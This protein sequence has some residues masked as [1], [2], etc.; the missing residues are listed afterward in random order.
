MTPVEIL[1][2]IVAG[3]ALALHFLPKQANP[4]IAKAQTDVDDV[5]T[6][7]ADHLKG[8]VAPITSA[9]AA[10]PIA[11]V[12]PG[13]PLVGPGGYVGT[14]NAHGT[15]TWA[16]PVPAGDT[17]AADGSLLVPVLAQEAVD[18]TLKAS[19]GTGGYHNGL[20]LN[21]INYL[22]ALDPKMFAA[23]CASLAAL[24]GCAGTGA[25]VG[26]ITNLSSQGQGIVLA[27]AET[28]L[29]I[30]DVDPRA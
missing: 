29:V 17:L 20:S 13:A 19:A 14:P 11:P 28:G 3:L 24:P 27:L 26:W 23:W 21:Q 2:L 8:H 25:S 6:W 12:V 15:V 7:I 22:K 10:Q 4:L 5:W 30:P 16:L 1:I 18:A 9:P